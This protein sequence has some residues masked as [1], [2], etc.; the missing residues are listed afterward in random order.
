MSVLILQFLHCEPADT[1]PSEVSLPEI[2]HNTEEFTQSGAS[3]K[4]EHTEA[5]QAC[6]SHVV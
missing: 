3:Y 6:V 2:S 1:E 4:H 5:G